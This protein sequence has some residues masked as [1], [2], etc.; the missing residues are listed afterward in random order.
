MHTCSISE[1]LKIAYNFIRWRA[2]PSN[3]PW[4][5][6][7]EL[8]INVFPKK[9]IM[10]ESSD[11]SCLWFHYLSDRRILN[12]PHKTILVFPFLAA[13]VFVRM[14]LSM[15]SRRDPILFKLSDSITNHLVSDAWMNGL[16][17]KM[18]LYIFLTA[19]E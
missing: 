2:C 18:P 14:V 12:G 7:N 5:S 16:D 3:L 6:T 13:D 15:F 4:L 1:R 10:Q 19:F 17:P 8:E 9:D 11:A